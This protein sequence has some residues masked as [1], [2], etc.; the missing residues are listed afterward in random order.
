[1]RFDTLHMRSLYRP[2]SLKT[3]NRNLTKYRLGL[4]EVQ[5]V[6]WEK[7]DT[8]LAQ[9]FTFLYGKGN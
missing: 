3:V 2:G 5:A 9:D 1:M 4:V 7:G 8:E 6:K